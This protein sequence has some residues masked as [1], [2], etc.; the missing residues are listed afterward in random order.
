AYET[1]YPIMLILCV[2][3]LFSAMVPIVNKYIVYDSGYAYLSKK[4]VAVAVVTIPI[5]IFLTKLHGV[6]GAAFSTVVTE[7]LSLTIFNYFFKSAV[8]LKIQISSL[9]PSTYK[10]VSKYE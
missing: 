3:S 8:V 2:N 1:A 7:F 6:E 4:T 5:A 10:I 9:K